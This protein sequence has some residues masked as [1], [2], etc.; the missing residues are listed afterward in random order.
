MHRWFP[1]TLI[2]IV[3][4]GDTVCSQ[5]F[6]DDE[7]YLAFYGARF[8]PGFEATSEPTLALWW[9][10]EEF[11]NSNT[12]RDKLRDYLSRFEKLFPDSK[13]AERV[14]SHLRVLDR[15]LGEK[16]PPNERRIDQLVYDLREL[17]MQ[18]WFQP[19][20]GLRIIGPGSL[21]FD[22]SMGNSKSEPD[23]AMQL[24]DIGY[25]AIPTLIDHIDDD[26]LTRSVDFWRSSTFSHGVLT[27]GECCRQIVDAILPLGH[28]FD[29]SSDPV[30]GKKKMKKYYSQ[31]IAKIRAEKSDASESATPGDTTIEGKPRRRDD[32]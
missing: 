23:A 2:A 20:S 29:V 5:T 32:Q 9:I 15:M 11:G 30:A 7:G 16:R 31:L 3:M 28:E 18:Q 8:N 25:D 13:H 4:L 1:L 24:L 12:P 26:T 17:N 21:R 19:N 22:G 14:K 10:I 27:V 6:S